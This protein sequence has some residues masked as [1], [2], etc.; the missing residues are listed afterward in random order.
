MLL[1]ALRRDIVFKL[2]SDMDY[3]YYSNFSGFFPVIMI[4]QYYKT[5]EF[6]TFNNMKI[7]HWKQLK[8]ARVLGKVAVLRPVCKYVQ[9]LIR[10]R[11]IRRWVREGVHVN[12]NV[13]EIRRSTRGGRKHAY[14]SK[15]L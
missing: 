3:C 5:E 12:A 6:N 11:K 8:Y 13:R 2:F 4:K 7:L 1:Y 14:H 9:H 15:S 10:I